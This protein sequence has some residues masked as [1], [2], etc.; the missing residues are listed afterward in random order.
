[1]SETSNDMT[2][3]GWDD[4]MSAWC[5]RYNAR[6]DGWCVYRPF[7]LETYG[8]S[9]KALMAAKTFRNELLRFDTSSVAEITIRKL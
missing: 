2:Y 4:K 1:M 8:S 3:I 6:Q 9:N 5:V 7:K